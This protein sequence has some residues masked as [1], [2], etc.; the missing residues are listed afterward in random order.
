MDV[1]L[2]LVVVG[3]KLVESDLKLAGFDLRL[4]RPDWIL[5]ESDSKPGQ[6]GLIPGELGWIPFYDFTI[7]HLRSRYVSSK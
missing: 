5:A 4:E 3:W 2:R 7:F 6:P 1:D